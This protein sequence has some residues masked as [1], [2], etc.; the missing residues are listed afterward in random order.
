[1]DEKLDALR[2]ECE[3]IQQE[4]DELRAKLEQIA[5]VIGADDTGK[6]IHDVRNVMNELVLLRELSNIED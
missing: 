4:R 1:M 3:A 5:Q 6:I 2:R